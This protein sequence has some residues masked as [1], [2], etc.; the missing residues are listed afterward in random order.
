MAGDRPVV[1]D[2]AQRAVPESPC[3]LALDPLDCPAR[4]PERVPDRARDDASHE[5]AGLSRVGLTG[6]AGVL[7]D[8]LTTSRDRERDAFGRLVRDTGDAFPMAWLRAGVHLQEFTRTIAQRT[9]LEAA[10]PPCERLSATGSPLAP[11]I[12]LGLGSQ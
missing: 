3:D 2:R 11:D 12:A 10:C 9:W 1:A 4:A 7:S 8:L 5:V 6:T